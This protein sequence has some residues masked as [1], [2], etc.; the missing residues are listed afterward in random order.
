[1]PLAHSQSSAWAQYKP[2]PAWALL[3]LA[4]IDVAVLHNNY[5][6]IPGYSS[7]PQGRPRADLLQIAWSTHE[8]DN[9][10]KDL[11][12]EEKVTLLAKVLEKE[13]VPIKIWAIKE[14]GK[15]GNKKAILELKKALDYNSKY[16]RRKTLE[17]LKK[18][19]VET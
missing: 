15:I 11:G 10:L 4:G 17:V 14:L 7:F 13:L 18:L 3:H 2:L 1:M 16:V 19:N 9:V 8:T 12:I 6:A 5:S